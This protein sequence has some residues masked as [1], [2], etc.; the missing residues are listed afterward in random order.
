MKKINTDKFH[1]DLSIRV[2]TLKIL[3][4]YPEDTFRVRDIAN[5][6][7]SV[8]PEANF[9]TIRNCIVT[10]FARGNIIE[11]ISMGGPRRGGLEYR[12]TQRGK[13]IS[14]DNIPSF[15][16]YKVGAVQPKVS[17]PENVT[18]ANE[19]VRN[20]DGS[21]SKLEGDIDS[22]A[23][24]EAFIDYINC[25]KAKIQKLSD[26]INNTQDNFNKELESYKMQ[27]KQKD[28]EINNPKE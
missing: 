10:D 5:K 15:L 26:M 7:M 20:T 21:F 9:N 19:V 17:M 2:L 24:G 18:S 28:S 25:L 27:V 13:D 12:L 22:F 16:S 8:R 6:V 4:T 23:L 14:P 11:K 3:Q 1:N